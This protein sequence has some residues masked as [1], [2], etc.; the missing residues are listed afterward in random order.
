MTTA[1]EIEAEA[2]QL[3]GWRRKWFVIIF[4]SHTPAGKAFDVALFIT[5]F[6]SVAVVM[7]ES[8]ATIRARYHEQLQLAEWVFTALFTVEYILRLACVP[9]PARYARS[10]FGV[11]D[12]LAV[13]PTYINLLFIGTH[14]LMIVR[15]MR[16]L[17]VFRVFKLARYLIEADVLI[18]ALQASRAKIFVF[19]CAVVTTVFVIGATMY[20]VEGESNGFT[21]IPRSVYW[22]IV[23]LTTVGYG[24]IAPQ[25]PLGQFLACLVMILGYGVIAVPTGIVSVELQQ[26]ARRFAKRRCPQCGLAQHEQD[27]H[28]CRACGSQLEHTD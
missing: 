3:T 16:L 7:L 21:S 26:A 22:A 19:L 24:D 12:L 14:Y 23:T 20:I 25:T 10:F 8:V 27:A 4:G 17:R 6:L 28:F 5:I 13:L 1:R 15:V 2:R 11:V 18:R 9:R